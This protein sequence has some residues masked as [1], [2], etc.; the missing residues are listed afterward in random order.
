M[1]L[2]DGSNFYFKLKKFAIN[3]S[4]FSFGTIVSEI[5]ETYDIL[6]TTYYIGRIRT[7]GSIKSQRMFD[8]QRKLLQELKRSGIQYSLGYL[9]K[10]GDAYHEKGVDVQM[11]VDIC[12]TAYEQTCDTVFLISSDTDLIPAIHIAMKKGIE[13]V[14]VGFHNMLSVALS[15]KATRICV[16]DQCLLQKCKKKPAKT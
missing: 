5:A 11:A 15:K 3:Q 16:L 14:Y 6:R 13:I 2:I 10:S 7:D 12:I 9:L 1:I 8:A 4:T